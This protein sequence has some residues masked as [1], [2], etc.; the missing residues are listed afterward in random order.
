MPLKVYSVGKGSFSVG[1]YHEGELLKAASPKYYKTREAA[2][3]A[4]KKRMI[5]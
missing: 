2:E 4:L 5:G 1:V 3:R